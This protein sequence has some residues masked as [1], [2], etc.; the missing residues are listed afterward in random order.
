[1][2]N[3]ILIDQLAD[4]FEANGLGTKNIDIHPG[5]MPSSPD[6]L[7]SIHNSGG[8]ESHQ[9]VKLANPTFQVLIRANLEPDAINKSL[10]IYELLNRQLNVELVE[11]GIILRNCFAMAPPQPIGVDDNQRIKYTLNFRASVYEEQ[12]FE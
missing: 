3:L 11:D 6:D 4:Y 2:D 9:E 8:F 5:S 1:M 7:I 10:R 12:L